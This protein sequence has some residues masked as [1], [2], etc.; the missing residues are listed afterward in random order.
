MAD[1]KAGKYEDIADSMAKLIEDAMQDEWN[2]YYHEVLSGMGEQDR[3]IMFKAVARGV[4]GYLEAHQADILT[5]DESTDDHH[6]NLLF[7]V[8]DT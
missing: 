5:S 7:G 2:H 1:L 3:L 8:S 4:L 6:H